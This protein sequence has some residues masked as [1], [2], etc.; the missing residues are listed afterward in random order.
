MAASLSEL[1][2]IAEIEA[3]TDLLSDPCRS[4][5][6]VRVRERFAVK[7]GLTIAPL[8]AENRKFVAANTNI[9]VPKVH[10][11]FIDPDTRKRYIIMDHLPGTDLEKLAPSLSEAQKKTVGKR[12]R[13]ALDEVRRIPSPGYLGNL[14][15]MPYYEGVLSTLDND[16][17]I[18]G[19]F[20]NE[21]QFNKGLLKALGQRE[22]PHYVRLLTAPIQHTLSGHKTVFVH[23]DL[24]PK[25]VIV[26]QHG[27]CEDGSPDYRITLID[28]SMAGWYPEYWDYCNSTVYC[29]ARP[30]WLELVPHIFDEYPL[31]YLM[32]R[33]FYTSMFY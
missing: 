25:N 31:E 26:E 20:E 11:D 13:E 7:V 6:V 15:R 29:Q 28:W 14:N 22:S 1:P 24:Q 3:S 4:V 27:A 17:R 19:P 10:A 21:D 23:G 12:I 32:M 8:E 2:S 9:L 5:K 16:P 33:I 18:S 30:A